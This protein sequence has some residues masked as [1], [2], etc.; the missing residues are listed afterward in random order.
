MNK[1]INNKLIY[2]YIRDNWDK[3]MF[4]FK[5]KRAYKD[6]RQSYMPNMWEEVG[7]R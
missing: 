3:I 1:R 7:K 2:E 5:S 6:K 4:S